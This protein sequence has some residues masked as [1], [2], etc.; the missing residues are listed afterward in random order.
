[1]TPGAAASFV[2]VD[3]AA[4]WRPSRATLLGRSINTPLLER[5]L[6]GVVQRTVL[7]GREAYKRYVAKCAT[8]VP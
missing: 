2:Q 1:V 4:S 5:E 6:P 8:I 7:E 3:L